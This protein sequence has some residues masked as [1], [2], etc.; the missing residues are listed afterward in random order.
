MVNHAVEA[1]EGNLEMTSEEFR[2]AQENLETL[3]KDHKRVVR[4]IG[5]LKERENELNRERDETRESAKKALEKVSEMEGRQFV[6]KGHSGSSN[7]MDFQAFFYQ[8][9]VCAR[10]NGWSEEEKENELICA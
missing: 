10:M 2:Q 1:G 8:F 5:E 7:D 6:F 4:Q 9:E 3:E